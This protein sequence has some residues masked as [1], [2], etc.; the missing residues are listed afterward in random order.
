MSISANDLR[1][2]IGD[3]GLTQSEFSRLLGVS[4]GAVAQWLSGARNIPGPVEAY[5]NL[6]LRLPPSLKEDEIE[7]VTKGH[8]NM[9]GMYLVKFAGTAGFGAAT[10][11][12][13]NGLVFGFDET[14][15]EYDGIYRASNVPGVVDVAVNVKMKAHQYTVAG[16]IS[17]PFDW[18]MQVTT[19]IPLGVKEGDVV[20]NTNV[21]QPVN[22]NFK[23]MRS[24]PMAA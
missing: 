5:F 9:D 21:G 19:R 4:I 20:V 15:G 10:L 12:F 18:T 22:A 13:S 16:G 8:V 23:F 3:L 24:L 2:I 14:G 1:N 17:H 11:T 7:R 6:L